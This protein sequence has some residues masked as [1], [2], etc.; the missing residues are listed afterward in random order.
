MGRMRLII[1][2]VATG[3]TFG[4]AARKALTA[5]NGNQ[6]LHVGMDRPRTRAL[7][8][9][10]PG[11]EQIAGYPCRAEPCAKGNGSVP[12][13]TEAARNPERREYSS[14][15]LLTVAYRNEPAPQAPV[16]PD[17]DAQRAAMKKL[18]FLAGKWTGE[19]RVYQASGEPQERI[20]TEEAQYK[21]DGLI[22]TIEGVARAKSD[23]KVVLQAL[24]IVS[25][26]D[27]TRTYRMRAFND[28]RFLESELKL[29]PD[30]KGMTW[31]SALGGIR[32]QALMRV[33]ERGEWTERH[34][35]AI[36]SQPARKFMEVTVSRD[37]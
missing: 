9:L 34:E 4:A 11:E 10:A 3:A 32:T 37:R 15:V 14:G 13:D 26:D 18:A 35:I 25:Y 1:L 19:A 27:R 12:V 7:T 22:L 21:L 28:G 30:G 5:P 24:G 20:Q 17:L 31:G 16:M 36:G 2:L 29:T 23:G 33:D 6:M 8:R